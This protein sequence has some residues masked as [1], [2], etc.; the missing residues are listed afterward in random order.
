MLSYFSNTEQTKTRKLRGVN[1]S[2]LSYSLKN[3]K[4]L[5]VKTTMNTTEFAYP[6]NAHK[7][8]PQ[9]ITTAHKFN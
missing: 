4:S 8:N 1:Q 6:K 2:L 3:L 9:M 5:K 7:E